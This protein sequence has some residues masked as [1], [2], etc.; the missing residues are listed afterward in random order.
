MPCE[1]IIEDGGK[2]VCF[3]YSGELI[4]SEVLNSVRD[5]FTDIEIIKSVEVIVADHTEVVSIKSDTRDIKQLAV[6]FMGACVQNENVAVAVI[7]PS[8]HLFGLCRMWEAYTVGISW[9][10]MVFRTHEE[11]DVWLASIAGVR[12]T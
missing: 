5:H 12:Q 6:F 8:D 9:G 1:V 11:A 7:A 4:E 2:K 3:R 10:L